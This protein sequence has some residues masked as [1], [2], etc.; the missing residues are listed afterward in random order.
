MPEKCQILEYVYSDGTTITKHELC[1][2]KGRR[3]SRGARGGEDEA[4]RLVKQPPNSWWHPDGYAVR[5]V[6]TTTRLVDGQI[7]VQP[8]RVEP[9]S[10]PVLLEVRGAG[11]H[12]IGRQR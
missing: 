1:D 9:Y 12:E 5:L 8:G 7:R 2:G 6:P 11:S 3:R 4:R 10:G